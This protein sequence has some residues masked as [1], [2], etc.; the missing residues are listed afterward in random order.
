M[1]IKKINAIL[2]ST[3]IIVF[4]ICGTCFAYSSSFSGRWNQGDT[5]DGSS[6][7][8][9]KYYSLDAK[10]TTIKGRANVTHTYQTTEV[11]ERLYIEVRRKL[12]FGSVREHYYTSDKYKSYI[13]FSTKFTPSKKGTHYLILRKAQRNIPGTISGTIIQ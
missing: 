8:N 11:S 10:K 13:N 2:V 1:K 9:S 7:N 3:F 5:I 12:F 6:S 4:M